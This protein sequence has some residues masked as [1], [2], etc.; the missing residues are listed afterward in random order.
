[1]H[2]KN[3]SRAGLKV[4][5]VAQRNAT[6]GET[7]ATFKRALQRFLDRRAPDVTAATA[8][9]MTREIIEVRE[10]FGRVR[11]D[12]SANRRGWTWN[13]LHVLDWHSEDV[14]LN[15]VTRKPLGVAS[16]AQKAM[17]KEMPASR[18]AH[19]RARVA[20]GKRLRALSAAYADARPDLDWA[21]GRL[22]ALAPRFPATTE[23]MAD[24]IDRSL[25]DHESVELGIRAIGRIHGKVRRVE[26]VKVAAMLVLSEI[27]GLGGPTEAAQ[28][29]RYIGQVFKTPH[30]CP[31][32]A[33]VAS[34][35]HIR[36]MWSRC[37]L[38]R[39]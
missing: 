23:M 8:N 32:F 35:E 4:T 14:E 10:A 18:T 26:H 37:G 25:E 39:P 9:R 33:E 34:D 38:T 16:D 29:A 27:H 30:P 13:V 1:M 15:E 6:D 7:E 11:A 3:R 36:K 22:G 21:I 17:T 5:P 20:R 19:D 28:I 2:R 12:A 31:A 24:L